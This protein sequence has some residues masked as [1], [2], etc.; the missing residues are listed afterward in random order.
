MRLRLKIVSVGEITV[1]YYP[2][3]DRTFVGGISLNFGVQAK[4]CG[5]VDVSLVSRIG[6]D[7]N[8]R[9]VLQTLQQEGIDTTHVTILPGKTA[10][11]TIHVNNAA[12][13]SFPPSGYCPNVLTNMHLDTSELAFIQQNDVL[14]ARYD[15][16]QPEPFFDQI[17]FD[18]NFEGRRV[19]DFGDWSG[20]DGD[21][22]R[23][24]RYLDQLDIAFVSGNQAAVQTLQPFSRQIEGIIV[25][26]LGAAGSVGLVNGRFLHQPALPVP[27]PLD[28]TGC[29]DAF[30]AAFTTTYFRTGNVEQ[31]LRQGAVLASQVIQHYGAI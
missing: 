22:G 12:E 24:F 20:F 10:T 31:A 13:R 2:E 4:R 7:G 11:C 26:T 18:L 28:T 30:Q 9:F 17:M 21:Y 6:S 27:N 1:D 8:G 3:L 23:M 16:G 5:E 15:H 25:V 29:G 14:V 19:A